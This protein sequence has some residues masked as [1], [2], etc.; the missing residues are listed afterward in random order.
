[1]SN[2]IHDTTSRQGESRRGASRRSSA[3][4]TL[5]V[6]MGALGVSDAEL[7]RRI[8]ETRQ[9]IHKKRTGQAAITADNISDYATALGID[10]EVLMRRPSAALVWLAE[11]HAERL[12]A[13][14]LPPGRQGEQNGTSH[15]SSKGSRDCRIARQHNKWSYMLGVSAT[16]A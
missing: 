3:P 7:G 12:D 10:P 14:E 16:A 8:G 6:V 15:L 1:M 9:N 13:L 5:T 4:R 2:H 11:H